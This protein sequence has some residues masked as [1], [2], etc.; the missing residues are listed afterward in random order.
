MVLAGLA[1]TL[2]WVVLWALPMINA[3]LAHVNGSVH[4]AIGLLVVCTVCFLLLKSLYLVATGLF[5]GG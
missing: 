5:P 1:Y 4:F 3:V 2:A